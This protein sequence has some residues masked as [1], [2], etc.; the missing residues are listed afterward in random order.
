MRD[1]F[2]GSKRHLPTL[3][4]DAVDACMT[5][6]QRKL[7]VCSATISERLFNA[8]LLSIM[9]PTCDLKQARTHQ[10]EQERE[11]EREREKKREWNLVRISQTFPWVS[12]KSE[13]INSANTPSLLCRQTKRCRPLTALKKEHSQRHT[14]LWKETRDREREREREERKA[15]ECQVKTSETV[16]SSYLQLHKWMWEKRKSKNGFA[17][18]WTDTKLKLRTLI[19][20]VR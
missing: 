11:R 15:N 9:R 20:T 14:P 6:L 2:E 17:L 8:F 4:L 16:L 13:L 5:R 3:W 19:Q 18:E 7:Q 10:Q 1:C 12:S